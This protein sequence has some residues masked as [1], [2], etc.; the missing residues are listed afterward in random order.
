MKNAGHT[1]PTEGS[2]PGAVLLERYLKPLGIAP[3]DLARSIGVPLREVSELIEGLRPITPD[4]AARLALF[5]DV[6]PR[7]WLMHQARYDAAYL[8]PV[9]ALRD[10]VT[11][12]GELADV[13]VTPHGA[14][15]LAPAKII[16]A[17][18]STA[19]FSEEFVARLRAQVEW[20]EHRPRTVSETKY[21]DGTVALVGR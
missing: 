18:T 9:E 10:A 1:I 3:S 5:F 12:F 11:P 6:P 8:A 19:T 2:H 20:T 16:P 13:L 21:P 14:T 15:R 17:E 7:W 4:V